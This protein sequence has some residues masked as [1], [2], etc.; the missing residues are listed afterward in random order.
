[1]V[2]KARHE[3]RRCLLGVG[4]EQGGLRTAGCLSADRGEIPIRNLAAV[5]LTAAAFMLL[6]LFTAGLARAAPP[7]ASPDPAPSSAATSSS[8]GASSANAPAPDPAPRAAPATSPTT[9]ASSAS[10]VAESA[11][12]GSLGAVTPTEGTS[13]KPASTGTLTIQTSA[14]VPVRQSHPRAHPARPRAHRQGR[15]VPPT[16]DPMLARVRG[17]LSRLAS[18]TALPTAVANDDGQLLLFS[19]LALGMLVIASGAMLRLLAR[20]GSE[21][22]LR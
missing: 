5:I 6:P 1:M 18:A 15:L 3:R 2:R 9:H 4:A 22:L 16:I 12:G 17:L 7:S 13:T 21:E 19:G 11:G 20:L 8:A 14:A 10:T